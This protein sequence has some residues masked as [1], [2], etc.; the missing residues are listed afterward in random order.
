MK[1]H[2]SMAFGPRVFLYGTRF[3]EVE[4]LLCAA[5]PGTLETALVEFDRILKATA[6]VPQKVLNVGSWTSGIDRLLGQMGFDV[7]NLDLD[8]VNPDSRHV[9]CDLN[10]PEPLP[11]EQGEFDLVFVQEVIEHL[12]NAWDLFRK[13]KRVLADNG[14][15]ILST[16]NVQSRMSRRMFKRHG[17]FRWFTPECQS[18]HI[19]PLF[20]WQLKLI[21]EQTG[22]DLVS[23]RG[24][25][26]FF[27]AADECRI[28]R[29]L[30]RNEGLVFILR[31]KTKI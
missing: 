10:R 22:F 13:V 28:E 9:K 8:F 25:G 27:L 2:K 24:N 20:F 23:V 7:I 16:P 1:A 19:N 18:Y 4:S 31:K 12:E 17:W 30:D 5:V 21:A 3:Y 11:F 14:E 29:I 15:M 6:P 26:D